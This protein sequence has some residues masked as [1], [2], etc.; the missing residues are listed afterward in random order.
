VGWE[1]FSGSST[2][3][4]T[5]FTQ[6]VNYQRALEGELKRTISSLSAIDTVEVHIV[7]PEKTLLSEDQAPTTAS[8]TVKE[9]LGE[10]LDAAQVRSITHLVASSVEG[11]KP[12]NV[13]VVDVNGNML[14]S[15]SLNG[16]ST[17][18]AM[19]DTRRAA[20]QAA[21]A[22][23]QKK[24][25]DLLD[26]TLG[27]GNAVV[28][29][30][31]TM[32]WTERQTVKQAY[33]PESATIRSFQTVTETLLTSGN[34]LGGIPGSATNLPPVTNVISTTG[35]LSNYQRRENTT[36]Y[37]ITQTETKEVET[38]GKIENISLSV[39][40][41][42]MTDQ[43]QLDNLR[44]VVAAAAGISEARGDTLEVKS[45]AFDRSAAQ[46]QASQM[47]EEASS[48]RTWQMVE[49]GA[50]LVALALILWYIQRLLSNLRLASTQAW[51]PVLKKVSEAALPQGALAGAGAGMNMP[52]PTLTAEV[53]AQ[54]LAAAAAPAPVAQGDIMKDPVPA[55]SAADEHLQQAVVNLAEENPAAIAEVIQIW[56]NEDKK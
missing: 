30:S 25:Q 27:K 55:M 12:E 40:V 39:M 43:A 32:D 44:A 9:K 56:L 50:G 5:E 31:V 36:N 21:A 6:R 7:S 16:G 28:K 47:E 20:E 46:A 37:E 3:G 26:T 18:M 17:A 48:Q 2:L 54:Q 33:D 53:A 19:T 1:L 41:D 49:I 35:Q 4:M 38:P 24:V 29:A 15:G 51:T 10:H 14:A 11:L 42:G 23:L 22:E 45:M 13:V 34:G 52:V 8:V